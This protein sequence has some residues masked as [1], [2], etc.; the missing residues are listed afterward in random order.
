MEKGSRE[1]FIFGVL[2]KMAKARGERVEATR[3]R[4]FLF[5]EQ[6]QGGRERNGP[7]RYHAWKSKERL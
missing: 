1:S 6:K 7:R 4:S 3:R 5:N 2:A